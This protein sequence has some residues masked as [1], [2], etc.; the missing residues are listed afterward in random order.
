MKLISR[1][2]FKRL[3]HNSSLRAYIAAN[4]RIAGSTLFQ[5]TLYEHTVVRELEEKLLMEKLK[6]CGGAFDK[7]VDIRGKW[8]IERI[9]EAFNQCLDETDDHGSKRVTVNGTNFK[10][11]RYKIDNSTFKPL[12]ILVQCKGFKH[13]KITSKEIRESVGAFLL[14]VRDVKR[15]ATI[16]FVASPNLLT[17][18]GLMAMNSLAI[19]MIYIR[20]GMLKSHQGGYDLENTGKLSNYYENEFAVKLL[21]GFGIDVWLKTQSYKRAQH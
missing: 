13:S 21:E 8:P 9:F 6:V 15:N 16:F 18:D 14:N 1:C 3:N 5:G 7:G 2:V 4:S 19:P 11:L 17:R 10:P 12:N 20:V